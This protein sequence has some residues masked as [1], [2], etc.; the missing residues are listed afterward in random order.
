MKK[1]L[2][3]QP[4]HIPARVALA[5]IYLKPEDPQAALPCAEEAVKVD[6]DDFNTDVALGQ[7]LLA[8]EDTA[9]AAR[10]TAPGRALHSWLPALPPRGSAHCQ[11]A[12]DGFWRSL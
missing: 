8:S 4:D 11:A 2:E 7:A 10:A 5:R 6:P 1:T 12:R 9:G 3:L